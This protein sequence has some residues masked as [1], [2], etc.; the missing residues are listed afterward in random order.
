MS[1]EGAPPG[2]S[3]RRRRRFWLVAGLGVALA[4]A[5]AAVVVDGSHDRPAP[6]T[7]AS[8]EEPVTD[9]ATVPGQLQPVQGDPVAAGEI[10]GD[11][12]LL[13]GAPALTIVT[14]DFGS[15]LQIVDVR[16]GGVRTVRL[17][18]K[19]T[20]LRPDAMQVVGDSL[21]V[22]TTGDVVR[23]APGARRPVVLARDHRSIFT[24]S[25]GSVWVYDGVETLM[26]G[27][28][29]RIGFDGTVHDRVTL[30]TLSQPLGGTADHLIVSAPGIVTRIDR[31]GSQREI[32]RGAGL[33]S[34]GTRLARLDCVADLSCMIVIGTLDDPDGT[35]LALPPDELP[36]GLFTEPRGRFSPDGRWLA[37]P[38]YRPRHDGPVDQSGVAVIDLLVG[39]EVARIDGSPLTQPH[40]PLGWSPDSGW[41]VVS[42]GT[43]LQAW[44]AADRDVTELDIG[45]S[46]TYALAV[47]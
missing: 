37:L 5:V 29:S 34:D 31:D 45:L 32:A 38:V 28:A 15:R 27:V 9:R 8:T 33:A 4:G 6:L 13:P 10:P 22:D 17:F 40:A 46:P 24:A 42:T 2:P 44:S 12:P 36:A 35:R 47:W 3:S 25:A 26:G 43:T 11:G 16:S 20:F 7:V 21:V 19:P 41:L 14:A 18:T 39:A 23:L 1:W 30:P